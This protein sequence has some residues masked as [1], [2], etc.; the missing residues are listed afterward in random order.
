MNK[1][2]ID[3]LGVFSDVLQVLNFAMNVSQSTTDE[4]M[5][6]LQHQN[7]DYLQTIIEQNKE[8]IERLKDYG[9]D[10]NNKEN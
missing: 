1:N 5:T 3:G 7:K 4:I 8:I 2:N 10:R 6:E 9:K